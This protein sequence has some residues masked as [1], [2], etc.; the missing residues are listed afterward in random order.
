MEVNLLRLKKGTSDYTAR[1]W[2]SSKP[3]AQA[4]PVL[5]GLADP[6]AG[7]PSGFNDL[8]ANVSFVPAYSIN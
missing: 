8:T 1:G 2:K 4:R 6:Q 7:A 5:R 3:D